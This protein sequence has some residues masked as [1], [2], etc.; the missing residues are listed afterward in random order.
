MQGRHPTVVRPA[1][2]QIADVATKSIGRNVDIDPVALPMLDLQTAWRVVTAHKRHDAVIG[3]RAGAKLS[4]QWRLGYG[5]ISDY[6][7]G[8]RLAIELVDKIALVH[9]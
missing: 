1:R 6:P 2:H 9:A 5:R 3:V 8:A 4:R 7:G